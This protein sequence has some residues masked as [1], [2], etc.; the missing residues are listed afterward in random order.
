MI[1]SKEEIKEVYKDD[2]RFTS[3]F[4]KDHIAD[5]QEKPLNPE[6]MT[7]Y[8][9]KYYLVKEKDPNK[10]YFIGGWKTKHNCKFHYKREKIERMLENT[11]AWENL[12]QFI[13][14]INFLNYPYGIYYDL[15]N[16]REEFKNFDDV[17]KIYIVADNNK[18]QDISEYN[19]KTHTHNHKVK[20]PEN[21]EIIYNEDIHLAKKTQTKI[22][23][24]TDY[25]CKML[26]EIALKER[27]MEYKE[28]VMSLKSSLLDRKSGI[29]VEAAYMGVLASEYGL[30]I[31]FFRDIHE[32][33]EIF[34]NNNK[35]YLFKLFEN[36]WNNTKLQKSVCKDLTGKSKTLKQLQNEL[37]KLYQKVKLEK[38]KQHEKDMKS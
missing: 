23:M 28:S 7:I 9:C 24:S 5:N 10:L 20:F 4:I 13:N 12:D 21:A 22:P 19:F 25:V 11:L 1:Y 8:T 38:S 27:V 29:G 37:D 2:D 3:W 6:D 18:G 26:A 15:S 34:M 31:Y 36:F 17:W 33:R 30:D 16:V 14:I 35:E 32:V